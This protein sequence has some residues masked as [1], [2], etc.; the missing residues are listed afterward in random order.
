MKFKQIAMG[1]Y[2]YSKKEGEVEL[3]HCIYGLTEEGE[4]YKYSVMQQKFIK[5]D[6]MGKCK[7]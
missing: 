5:L 6:T 2:T 4:V 7:K 3:S 1:D